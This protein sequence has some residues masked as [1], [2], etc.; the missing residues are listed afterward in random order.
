MQR[1]LNLSLLVLGL[2]LLGCELVDNTSGVSDG[3]VPHE[4]QAAYREDAARL[5]LRDIQG[6]NDFAL[7]DIVMDEALVDSFYQ[8]L[9]YVYQ[10]DHPARDAV[11]E[12]YQIHTFPYPE[13]RRLLVQ[14]NA[15]ATWAE[16]WR[17]GRSLTGEATIDDLIERYGLSLEHFQA[18]S[19]G[20]LAIL[21]AEA[22][23]NIEGLAGRFAEITGVVYAE[24]DGVVGGGAD[25]E[26]T[27]DEQSWRLAYSIGFGDCP[28]GCISRHYWNFRVTYGGDVTFLGE[29]GDPLPNDG[30]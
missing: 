3:D 16:A 9:V 6:R 26:A 10:T 29:S 19:T 21:H 25:I 23:L 22:P 27:R 28:A 24:P 17:E 4:L 11:V 20:E 2:I 1:L 18:T 5:A 8:A 15:E 13:M 7:Y 12:T 14:V 30:E